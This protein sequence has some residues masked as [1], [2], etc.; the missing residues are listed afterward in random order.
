MADLRIS[1]LPPVYS[2]NG[3]DVVPIVD[4]STTKKV[5]LNDLLNFFVPPDFSVS[6]SITSPYF[7]GTFYGDGTHLTGVNT[8]AITLVIANSANWIGTYTVVAA[9]SANWNNTYTNV[10]T[11]SGAWSSAAALVIS[12]SGNWGGGGTAST[13][14]QGYSAAWQDATTTVQYNSGSWNSGGTTSTTVQT[15]SAGWSAGATAS[16]VVNSF[17]GVW[18]ARGGGTDRVFFEN[19][20]RVTTNYTITSGKNAMSSGPITINNGVT[21]TIPNGSVYKIV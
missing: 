17:S 19:D 7:Y 8:S 12:N 2:V 15:N 3:Y 11:N 14:V 4:N 16:T 20:I 21:V 9:N 6:N 13:I 1:D 10:T 18:G 5:A